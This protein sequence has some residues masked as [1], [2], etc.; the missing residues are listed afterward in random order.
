MF[1][2]ASRESKLLDTKINEPVL[3]IHSISS[4]DDAIDFANIKYVT[5]IHI[6]CIN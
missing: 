4:L 1:L 5:E 2:T 6:D 3:L